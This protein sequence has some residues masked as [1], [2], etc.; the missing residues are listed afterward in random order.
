MVTDG[1]SLDDAHR[2]KADYYNTAA[3]RQVI[4]ERFSVND[5]V[6]N[7]VMLNWRGIWFETSQPAP[8]SNDHKEERNS[9]Y[10]HQSC[11]W[12]TLL[13]QDIM[14]PRRRSKRGIR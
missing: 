13:L 7:T 12:V 6:F 4:R 11:N 14:Q 1:R 9:H 3:I 5:V 2:R 8:K 10:K